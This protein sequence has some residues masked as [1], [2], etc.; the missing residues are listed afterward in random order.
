MKKLLIIYA[1]ISTAAVACAVR[2]ISLLRHE[3]RR[4]GSNVAV[5]SDDLRLYRTRDGESAAEIGSL[6]LRCGELRSRYEQIAAENRRLGIRLR[7]IESI[8]AA[9]TVTEIDT[10][11]VLRDSLALSPVAPPEKL[12]TLFWAD[13][14]CTLRAVLAGD[15]LRLHYTSVD[16]LRQTVYRIPRRFL[17]IRYGTKELRQV[18]T[19][20]NPHTRLV[21]SSHITVERRR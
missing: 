16:T 7:Q 6:R 12:R 20:S 10:S 18:I 4:L 8:A 19:S 15:S 21:Y 3:N 17:F 14:W 1:V 2:S 9:A 11:A 13:D 5:L